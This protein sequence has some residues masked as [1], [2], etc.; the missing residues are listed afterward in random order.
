MVCVSLSAAATEPP[1]VAFTITIMSADKRKL[2]VD[3]RVRFRQE[4]HELTNALRDSWYEHVKVQAKAILFEWGVYG[5]DISNLVVYMRSS[6]KYWYSLDQFEASKCRFGLPRLIQ[7]FKQMDHPEFLLTVH[8]VSRKHT[9]VCCCSHR[10]LFGCRWIQAKVM[11]NGNFQPLST[12]FN[13]PIFKDQHT[14]DLVEAIR[15][16]G[17]AYTQG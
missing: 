5:L 2:S 9:G 13:D 6:E 4:E 16:A 1:R 15:D 14:K 11:V 12:A 7:D 10:L 17:T 3:R 8:D